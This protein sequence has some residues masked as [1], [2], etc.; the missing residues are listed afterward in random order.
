MRVTEPK[1][2]QWG[3]FTLWVYPEDQLE[4]MADGRFKLVIEK[5]DPPA[6]SRGHRDRNEL[7]WRRDFH[8]S[9]PAADVS[10]PAD[11]GQEGK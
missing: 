5:L 11:A 7:Y 8:V 6:R 4:V 9:I 10:G 3:A 1:E 2:Y